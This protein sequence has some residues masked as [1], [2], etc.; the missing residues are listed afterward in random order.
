M[1]PVFETNVGLP[2]PVI[3]LGQRKGYHTKDFP[4]LSS[5]AEVG[6][7][8]LEFK[9]LSHLTGNDEYW[10]AV[11]RVMKVVKDARL[12]HGLASIFLAIDEGQYYTSAI[13]LGSRGDS[14]YEYLLYVNILI[15]FGVVLL[16]DYQKAIYPNSMS[17]TK[18]VIILLSI[19]HRVG[20]NMCTVMYVR[21]L[22]G[23]VHRTDAFTDVRRCYAGCPYLSSPEKYGQ[24][25]DLHL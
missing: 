11:E 22:C 16:N 21:H 23:L 8:Q 6:T 10:R 24:S 19:A 7:L 20:R 2:L 12:P 1:L 4:G 14:F 5:I 15:C 3:N 13:R 17:C 18:L 9:Y 25:N